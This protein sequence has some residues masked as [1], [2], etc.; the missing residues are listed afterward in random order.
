M[1]LNSHLKSVQL[2]VATQ[3]VTENKPTVICRFFTIALYLV[4]IRLLAF[5][6]TWAC[7]WGIW[8]QAVIIAK[9][10]WDEWGLN[11]CIFLFV[12]W[13]MLESCDRWGKETPILW[14]SCGN[15]NSKSGA[16]GVCI[17]LKCYW[18]PEKGGDINPCRNQNKAASVV[19]KFKELL[20]SAWHCRQRK[21]QCRK[22][23]NLF[24]SKDTERNII[25]S[26]IPELRNLF[27]QQQRSDFRTGNKGCLWKQIN[28]S[29]LC[30]SAMT[31]N[32]NTCQKIAATR[33]LHLALLKDWF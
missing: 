14:T 29:W 8:E 24:P 18:E 31:K 33:A 3:M 6:C 28:P 32:F 13:G 5:A 23:T 25:N 2:H 19:F 1:Q 12:L 16:G 26:A 21:I 11:D 22:Q 15:G 9:G 10:V 30:V 27:L 20:T 4:K 7:N 17:F